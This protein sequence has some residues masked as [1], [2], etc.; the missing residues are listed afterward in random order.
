MTREEAIE[1]IESI[2]SK[3][4]MQASGF[5]D[6]QKEE[7]PHDLAECIVDIVEQITP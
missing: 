5:M 6:Y 7:D 4:K 1:E 2:I 3:A